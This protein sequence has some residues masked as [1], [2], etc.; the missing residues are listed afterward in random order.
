MSLGSPTVHKDLSL[1]ILVPRWTGSEIAD[2]LMDLISSIEIAVRIG[3]WELLTRS[4][5][6]FFKLA[7]SAKTFYK[8]CS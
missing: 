3:R 5:S 6:Q 7:S 4:K 2:T 8:V 1:I